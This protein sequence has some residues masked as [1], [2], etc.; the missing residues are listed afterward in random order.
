MKIL[1]LKKSNDAWIIHREEVETL[2]DGFCDLYVIIDAI[3]FKNIK[4]H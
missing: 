1:E 3:F 4:S 2:Q